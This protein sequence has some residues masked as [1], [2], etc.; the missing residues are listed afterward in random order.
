MSR[1]P[2]V[3]A[4]LLLA[5]CT[6]DAPVGEVRQEPVVIYTDQLQTERLTALFD[7]YTEETGAVVIVRH[8]DPEAVVD[9]VIR[10]RISPP[11]DLLLTQ[12]VT[13]VYRAALE[14]ALR[15]MNSPVVDERVPAA[16]RDPDGFWIALTYRGTSIAYRRGAVDAGDVAGFEAL[17]DPALKGRLCL[18]SSMD[19]HNLAVIAL[20]I[21]RLGVHD[22]E[23]VVRGWVANLARPVF[24]DERDLWQA[25]EAGGCDASLLSSAGAA[26]TARARIAN[27]A[28]ETPLTDSTDVEAMGIA[29]HARNP[30]G[31]T[32]MVEWLLRDDAQAAFADA[33]D[34]SPATVDYEGERNVGTVG[35]YRD[36]AVSLAERARYP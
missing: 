3:F 22:A 19:S 16:L 33:A 14:G 10:N 8:A 23:L 17:A 36:E 2:F 32:R 6:P 13:G 11:A 15:P 12:S 7:A 21:D 4:C 31:A 34:A 35:W 30:D 24:A 26:W 27:I 1:S 18:S 28:I 29:R 5:A 9:D 20:L 25:I